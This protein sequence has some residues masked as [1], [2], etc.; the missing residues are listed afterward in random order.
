MKKQAIPE[1]LRNHIWM[2]LQTVKA[3]DCEYIYST[4]YRVHVLCLVIVTE[5]MLVDTLL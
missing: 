5:F 3:S 4:D 1:E 2:T